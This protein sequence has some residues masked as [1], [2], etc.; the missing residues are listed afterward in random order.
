[1]AGV[2]DHEG[3][4]VTSRMTQGRT[5]P[6]SARRMFRQ[7][8]RRV[9]PVRGARQ[10]APVHPVNRSPG[11]KRWHLRLLSYV[12]DRDSLQCRRRRAL[13]RG[14]DL[15][16]RRGPASWRSAE[17][18]PIPLQGPDFHPQTALVS[19]EPTSEGAT[20]SAT[21][22]RGDCPTRSRLGDPIGSAFLL[23]A[24]GGL[25]LLAEDVRSSPRPT[26]KPR[27]GGGP[28]SRRG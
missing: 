1:M 10:V 4:C 13:Q 2:R 14:G 25:G 20:P 21:H 15:A 5:G 28:R 9:R 12:L 16:A 22:R 11:D 7:R 18:C 24:L 8:H 3:T 26:P 17:A 19:L 27:Q 23:L 6:T